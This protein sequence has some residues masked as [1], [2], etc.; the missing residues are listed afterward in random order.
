MIKTILILVVVAVLAL[1]A[2][3]ATRPDSFRLERKTVIKAPPEKIFANLVDFNKWGAWSP[4]EKLEPQMKRTHGGAPAG[5][6]ANYAWE[7]NKVGAGRMEILDATPSSSVKIKLDFSKP[8]EAHNLVDFTL[9]PQGDSTEV[10]WAMYGPMAFINKLFG[11]FMSMDK[12]VGKDFE[13]GLAD[14]KA[15]SEK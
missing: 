9:T 5:K 3:A 15:V 8:F 10:T 1:L 13:A 2:F 4:W 11:V 7:G 6:G 14:L 12:M